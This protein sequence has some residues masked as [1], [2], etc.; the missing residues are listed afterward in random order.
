M[1]FVISL[2]ISAHTKFENPGPTSRRPFL[3]ASGAFALPCTPRGSFSPGDPHKGIQNHLPQDCS[4]RQN[5][6]LIIFSKILAESW[7][8]TSSIGLG[9]PRPRI[10]RCLCVCNI[11]DGQFRAQI[12]ILESGC[13]A[14]PSNGG[15]KV[16]SSFVC[17][18]ARLT[19]VV[20]PSFVARPETILR[21]NASY[22]VVSIIRYIK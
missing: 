2:S 22:Q 1:D 6:V 12:H 5:Q 8:G 10:R 7:S 9:S 3:A 17:N 19:E 14:R 15:Y 11:F 18:P 4:G 21:T 20:L 16:P 13:K